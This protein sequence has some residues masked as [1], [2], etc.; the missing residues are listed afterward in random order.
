MLKSTRVMD[1]ESVRGC[2]MGLEYMECWILFIE[3]FSH[4]KEQVHIEGL[5]VYTDSNIFIY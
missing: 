1:K 5:T 4:V 2:K 3:H